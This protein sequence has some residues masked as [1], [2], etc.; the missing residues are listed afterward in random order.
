MLD[1]NK[2]KELQ[3]KALTDF[4]IETRIVRDCD[5]IE[6][7]LLVHNQVEKIGDSAF[8][9]NIYDLI[10]EFGLENNVGFACMP[11]AFR[12]RS[13]VDP[14]DFFL[15]AKGEAGHNIYEGVVFTSNPT[16]DYVFPEEL[17]VSSYYSFDEAA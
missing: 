14:E 9:D 16:F 4:N 15:S 5:D 7:I 2:I 17:P 1:I 3:I 13:I 8:E 6:Q 12:E 11:I 10:E